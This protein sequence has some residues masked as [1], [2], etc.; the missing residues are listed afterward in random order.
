MQGAGLRVVVPGVLDRLLDAFLPVLIVEGGDRFALAQIAAFNE[1]AGES[2]LGALGVQWNVGHRQVV[3]DALANRCPLGVEGTNGS[4]V[5]QVNVLDEIRQLVDPALDRHQTFHR[6]HGLR[7]G[8]QR[9]GHTTDSNVLDVRCL[10]AQNGDDLVGLALH[11]ECLQVVRDR[12]QIH[13]GRKFHRRVAPVAVGEDAEL[14]A[15]DEMLEPLV[16]AAHL[17]L[18]VEVPAGEA[19]AQ[20]RGL[21]RI[22]FQR[23]G[24]IHPV[25]RR[26]VV[27]VNNEVVHRVRQDDQV[28]DVL[29]VQRNFHLERVLDRAHRGDGMHGGADAAD[30]LRDGP[31]VAWIAS[32][33]NQLD[34]TPHLAGGPGFLHLAAVDVDIDPQVAFDAGDRI[35]RDAFGHLESPGLLCDQEATCAFSLGRTGKRRVMM[36]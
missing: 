6:Q 29:G 5:N 23:R 33:Q 7:I 18:A 1:A 11:F 14:A 21:V 34:A 10:G 32:Q 36:M 20:D 19:L 3:G 28:A 30:A 24:H 31:G 12:Q 9:I 35:N 13:F 15:V 27:E 25:Q 2:K 26:Q 22:G 8:G 16:H 4:H 17:V